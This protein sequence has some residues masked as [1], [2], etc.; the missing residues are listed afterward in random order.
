MNLLLTRKTLIQDTQKYDRGHWV[1]IIDN[2]ICSSKIKDLTLNSTAYLLLLGFI[3]S[4]SGSATPD[5]SHILMVME[6]PQ[7]YP[8]PV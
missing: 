8:L 4:G 7:E 5:Y 3:S 6:I 2:G 1:F